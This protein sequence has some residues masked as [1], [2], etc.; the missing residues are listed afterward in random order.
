MGVVFDEV[1]GE[2]EGDSTPV[3]EEQ[4]DQSAPEGLQLDPGIIRQYLSRLEQ[5]NARLRAD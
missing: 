4:E 3:S 5:R 2:V 1:V